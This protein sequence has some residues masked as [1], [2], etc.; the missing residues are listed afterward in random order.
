MTCGN[1][2]PSPLVEYNN[3]WG[4]IALCPCGTVVRQTTASRHLQSAPVVL[5]YAKPR[6]LS[7]STPRSCT[8]Q[9]VAGMTP[10]HMLATAARG[11]LMAPQMQ[12]RLGGEPLSNKELLRRP[13]I[14]ASIGASEGSSIGA[15]AGS[16]GASVMPPMAGESEAATP[17]TATGVSPGTHGL[18]SGSAAAI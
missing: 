13:L 16:S 9:N 7:T 12:R 5:R 14:V 8:D 4:P 17:V 2:K 3:D 1:D 11:P 15:S 10:G 18:R 6:H